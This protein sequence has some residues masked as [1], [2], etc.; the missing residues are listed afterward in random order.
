MRIIYQNLKDGEVKVLAENLDDLWYLSQVI[1]E[2]DFVSGRSFRKIKIG[3]EA[4]RGS[5]VKRPVFVKVEVE[6]V[7]L[8][9]GDL[10]V[11]GVVREGSD[12]VPRGSHHSVD[13]SP[14]A[15]ITVFKD[16]WPKFQLDRIH[17]ATRDDYREVLICVL[18]RDNAGFALLKKSG[19][20]MLDEVEGEVEKKEETVKVRGEGFFA[21]VAK[22]V[23]DY[24]DR[25]GVES[26]ILASPA[27]WKE[28]LFKI[29]RKKYPEVAKKVT[30]ATCSDTG[31]SGIDE[32]LKRD[33]VRT[34]L[35]KDRTARELKLVDEL[36]GG[37]ARDKLAAYGFDAVKGAVEVKAVAKLLVTDE[38]IQ[39][40][41]SKGRFRD[42]ELL[43]RAVD[44]AGGDVHII[45]VDNDGGRK[46][47]GIGGI[48]AVLRYRLKY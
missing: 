17:E 47:K 12:E 22:M 9:D 18:E 6:K 16:S 46:L 32:V 31:K 1:D 44:R 40:L 38:I 3:G 23:K 29:V 20:S 15:T 26:I 42:L 27:F 41:R 24:A 10:R 2:G 48:G 35:Q 34:V 45:A 37:I 28:D 11:L 4:E 13:V 8:A 39:D 14:G 21:E 36:L 33:E 19:Y 5:V 25:Y 30:L 7:E 43:M